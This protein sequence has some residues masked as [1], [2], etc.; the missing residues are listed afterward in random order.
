MLYICYAL[1]MVYVIVNLDISKE[2]LKINFY[3]FFAIR[4]YYII[5]TFRSFFHSD[6]SFFHFRSQIKLKNLKS[7]DFWSLI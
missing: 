7:T 2:L 1:F 4:R 5:F 6:L 3:G